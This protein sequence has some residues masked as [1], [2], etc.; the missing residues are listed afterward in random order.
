M[1]IRLCGRLRFGVFPEAADGRVLHR[2]FF[3][4]AE[5]SLDGIIAYLSRESGGNVHDR[6]I[7]E[8]TAKTV[9]GSHPA[10]CA[11]DL[12]SDNYYESE[13]KPDQW[14]CFNFKD[15]RVRPS[16]YSIH[17]HSSNWWLRSWV[18]EGSEDNSKWTVLDEQTGN[19]RTNSSHPIGTFAVSRSSPCQWIRLR[20]TGKNVQGSDHLILF[21]VEL[22][23]E[24]I[25]RQ[26]VTK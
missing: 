10:K 3:P 8:L 2:S 21:A 19:D 15:R 14:I 20:Q 23:G 1:W 18:L 22:F 4:S 17:A 24:L 9:D 16:H 12:K 5:G 11:V 13:D 26:S 7:V 6:T 25:E